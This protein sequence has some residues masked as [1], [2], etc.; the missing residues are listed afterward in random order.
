MRSSLILKNIYVYRL[1]CL[2]WFETVESIPCHARAWLDWIVN[3]TN[4]LINI[5]THLRNGWKMNGIMRIWRAVALWA[6][7]DVK[8]ELKYL[9]NETAVFCTAKKSMA[10]LIQSAAYLERRKKLWLEDA[11]APSGIR[12]SGIKR[13]AGHRQ[14]DM[15]L[16]RFA[17][18]LGPGV[19]KQ[20]DNWIVVI[21][22]ITS[23]VHY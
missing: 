16:G 17:M 4:S 18:E 22:V 13:M 10:K 8:K 19:E 6:W 9:N 12:Y 21:R 5:S 15:K 11:S 3:V 1:K 20:W 7:N 2:L 14:E 23:H